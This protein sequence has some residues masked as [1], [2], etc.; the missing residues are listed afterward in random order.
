MMCRFS[1]KKIYTSKLETE[2]NA[3]VCFFFTCVIENAHTFPYTLWILA[4]LIQFKI[5]NGNSHHLSKHLQKIIK[6]EK[7]NRNRQSIFKN[8]LTLLNNDFERERRK[9]S[10]KLKFNP[11]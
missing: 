8:H 7:F 11:V 5:L 6:N 9:K 3:E 2:K 1:K 4:D 10:A